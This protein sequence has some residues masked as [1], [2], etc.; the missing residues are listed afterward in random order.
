MSE[1]VLQIFLKKGAVESDEA[2]GIR[3]YLRLLLN[4]WILFAV[5]VYIFDE[6]IWVFLVAHVPL[7]IAFPLTGI[8]KIFIIF[9]SAFVL[10]E[11]ISKSEWIGIGFISIGLATIIVFEG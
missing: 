3:Y 10:K 9:F 2:H 5:L 7:S 4:K 1:S 11:Y 6:V 8:Q